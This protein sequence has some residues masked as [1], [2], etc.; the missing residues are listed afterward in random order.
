MKQ[1]CTLQ[2]HVLAYG[3]ILSNMNYMSPYETILHIINPF[4]DI[5]TYIAQ[6]KPYVDK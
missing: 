6:Y 3:L 2:I 4:V 5:R 1:Y